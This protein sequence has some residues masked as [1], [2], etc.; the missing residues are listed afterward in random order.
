MQEHADDTLVGK[1]T[2]RVDGPL[3]VTGAAR[4]AAEYD[5]PD[6]LHGCVVSASIAKG[7]I[8]WIDGA[9]ARALPGVIDVFTH[10]HRPRASDWSGDYTDMVGPPGDAFRPLGSERILFSGQPVAL[11][12]AESFEAARDASALVRVAYAAEPHCTDLHEAKAGSYKPP[13]KR[14]GIAPPPKP[15]GDFAEAFVDAPVKF[16]AE[17]RMPIEHHNPM[18]PFASTCV[19]QGDGSV[20]VYDKTQ[21]SLN[22]QGYLAHAFKLPKRKVRVV[23]SFVGGAFGSGLRPQYQV[24]LA[25]LASLALERSVRVVLTRDQMF[26]LS[27]RPETIQTI[28][29][30]ADIDGRLLAIGHRAVANTSS[31]EDHQEPVVNWSSL[32]YH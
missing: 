30:G 25:V 9:A 5:A 19:W 6:L 27:Y 3:K 11:V 15:R 32:L 13:K 1:P 4:Y 26:T 12:V 14:L 24:F 20:L 16:E 10:E 21:G 31:F 18:E 7:R 28:T 2:R 8:L 22:V 29:L 17:Y 23:N